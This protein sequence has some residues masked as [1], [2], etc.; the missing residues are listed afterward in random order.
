MLFRYDFGEKLDTSK[1]KAQ[2]EH[3]IGKIRP[4]LTYMLVIHS[5]ELTVEISEHD[6]HPEQLISFKLVSVEKEKL[7]IKN[8]SNV[9]PLLDKRFKEFEIIKEIWTDLYD[10][11]GYLRSN[12]K[13]YTVSKIIELVEFL[14]KVEK[15]KA[16]L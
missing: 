1:F 6:D 14:F 2:A 16:F 12:N 15:L 4:Q 10:N 3:Y 11:V 9:Y 8:K 13:T 7:V 5:Y